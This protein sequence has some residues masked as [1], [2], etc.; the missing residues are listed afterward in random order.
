MKPFLVGVITKFKACS[1]GAQAAIWCGSVAV[2]SSA[3]VVPVIIANTQKPAEEAVV[4]EIPLEDIGKGGDIDGEPNPEMEPDPEPE[5]TPEKPKEEVKPELTP[6]PAP[7]PQTKP[8]T[9]QSGNCPDGC[10]PVSHKTA[11]PARGASN[12]YEER[13]YVYVDGSFLCYFEDGLSKEELEAYWMMNY[14]DE[15][16]PPSQR[17]KY[18]PSATTTY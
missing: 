14:G 9:S 11:L 4:E 7:Q 3:I 16:L 13:C 10:T 18:T 5:P 15:Y 1:L 8:T 17:P 12:Y 2:V 6:T